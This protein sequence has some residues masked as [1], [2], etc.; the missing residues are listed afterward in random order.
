MK[1]TLYLKFIF[2]YI[3]FGFLSLFYSRNTDR[4]PGQYAD[5]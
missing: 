5:F 2:I 1:S 3:V 4:E